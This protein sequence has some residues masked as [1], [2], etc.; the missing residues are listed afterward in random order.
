MRMN[1]TEPSSDAEALARLAKSG[2]DLS[3]LHRVEF[4][5]RFPTEVDAARATSQ[6]E[7]L[8][9]ATTT[10]P[11][12]A[13]DEWV[14]LASKVMYPVESD[15]MGLRD[16]LNVVAAEGH[17]TYNGWRATLLSDRTPD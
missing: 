7:D 13:T 2:S 9:F 14:I 6:L 8:A 15:L 12:E 5:L 4:L 17:G 10:E 3:K 16:K 11:D 1:A